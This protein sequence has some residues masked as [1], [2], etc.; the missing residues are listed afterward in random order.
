[1]KENL[2][3]ASQSL[4]LS[5][6]TLLNGILPS[7][8]GCQELIQLCIAAEEV[9]LNIQGVRERIHKVERLNR[10]LPSD[11]ELAIEILAF[12]YLGTCSDVDC[13]NDY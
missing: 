5:S 10:A 13:I 3:S 8:S 1:M 6:L 11:N 2:S 9:P 7:S 12:W 4:R